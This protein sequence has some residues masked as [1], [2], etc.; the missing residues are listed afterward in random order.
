[1]KIID[2]IPVWGDPIDE[3]AMS[4]IRTCKRTAAREEGKIGCTADIT[5]RNPGG[6]DGRRRILDGHQR[7]NEAN[8]VANQS[9]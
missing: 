8:P 6:L 2:D 9:N 7:N 3:G 1:M 5:S 4:Q